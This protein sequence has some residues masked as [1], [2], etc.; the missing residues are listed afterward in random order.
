MS[1]FPDPSTIVS[2]GGVS[3]KWSLVTAVLGCILGF[4][5]VS[6]NLRKNGYK[7]STADDLL[8]LMMAGVIIGGRA[9][10]VIENWHSYSL[11]AWGILEFS[12]GGFDYAGSLLGVLVATGFYTFAHHMS[13]RRTSDAIMPAVLVA[14]AFARIGKIPEIENMWKIVAMDAIGIAV[15]MFGIRPYREGRR[16][17]DMTS[18]S[19]MIAGIVQ[20]L[21]CTFRLDPTTNSSVI[22]PALAMLAGLTIYL[23]TRSLPIVKPVVL[24]DFDG[25][26][27]DSEY[28]VI[29]GFAY[30]YKKHRTLDEFTHEIQREVFLHPLKEEIG[31]LFPEENAEAL[32]REYRGYMR[33]IQGRHLVETLPHVRET[34][35]QLKDSGY[36]LG[37][38]TGRYTDSC[39]MWLEDLQIDQYFDIV[40]GTEMYRHTKPSPDGILHTC[41]MLKVG[42]DSCVYVGDGVKDVQAGKNAG[43]YTVAFVTNEEK[44]AALE[45][46]G[47]NVV[48]DSFDQLPEILSRQHAWSSDL[49]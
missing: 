44:R 8:I 18:V 45:K 21:N 41:E 11:Y 48:M 25:T 19:L 28:L 16:R 22:A 27:M 36:V 12:D 29:N 31:R 39:N 14:I 5:M 17:G 46:A 43:V 24:F 6:R 10:W 38:V 3:L 4:L 13:Y 34:L 42:H 26:L 35:K 33:D 37:V 9:V 23:C 30:L 7:Q 49:Y 2:I 32:A 1:F 20:L 47:P 15:L 40:S